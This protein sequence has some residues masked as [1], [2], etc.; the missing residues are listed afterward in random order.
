MKSNEPNEVHT[1]Q[2][3]AQTM[4]LEALLGHAVLYSPD[5]GQQVRQALLAGADAL[6]ANPNMTEQEKFG[7]LKTLEGA[8]AAM[9]QVAAAL[10]EQAQD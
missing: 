3:V 7:C 4:I 8:V 6:R 2:L 5:H 1:G 9:D 10:S